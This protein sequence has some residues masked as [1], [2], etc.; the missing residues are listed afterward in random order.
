MSMFLKSRSEFAET[1]FDFRSFGYFH[2]LAEVPDSFVKCL[3]FQ[4]LGFRVGD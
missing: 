3:N 1:R 4:R 2:F